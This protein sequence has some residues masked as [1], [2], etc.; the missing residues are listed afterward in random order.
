MMDATHKRF[1]FVLK[2][3]IASKLYT[4]N[5]KSWILCG[6]VHCITFVADY[7]K[8]NE[9]SKTE[10]LWRDA[11]CWNSSYAIRRWRRNSIRRDSDSGFA[12]LPVFRLSLE[13]W[14]SGK[15][16]SY[17]DWGKLLSSLLLGTM[18]GGLEKDRAFS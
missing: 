11:S 5:G 1:F 15:V 9:S 8:V 18:F 16:P 14:G 12:A 7:A 4:C 3:K 13:Q 2:Y 6:Q 10:Q 17:E